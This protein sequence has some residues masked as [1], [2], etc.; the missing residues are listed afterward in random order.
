MATTT[1][2]A[3]PANRVSRTRAFERCRSRTRSRGG[4]GRRGATVRHSPA[5]PV[6]KR[7]SPDSVGIDY[8]IGRAWRRH[9]P[10]GVCLLVGATHGSCAPGSGPASRSSSSCCR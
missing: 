2:R 3:A 1:I 9:W 6:R 7:R 10:A 8:V 4:L 5:H